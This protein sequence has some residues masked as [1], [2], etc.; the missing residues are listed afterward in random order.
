MA[1]FSVY[2]L[3]F[4]PEFGGNAVRTLITAII[5]AMLAQPVWA[6]SVVEMRAACTK[7]QESG[8]TYSFQYEPDSFISLICVNYMKAMS[9]VGREQCLSDAAG[10]DSAWEAS[11]V[12]LAQ[13][14]LEEASKRP[15]LENAS[16]YRLLMTTANIAFPCKK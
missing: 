1:A 6:Y 4:T 8:Y 12:Q 13:H 14:F 3:E 16:V 11:D 2:R 7:W 5:L 15:D 9:D 10:R